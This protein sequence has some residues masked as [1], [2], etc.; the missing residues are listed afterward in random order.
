MSGSGLFEREPLNPHLRPA[1]VLAKLTLPFFFWDRCDGCRRV[2]EKCEGGQPCRRCAH[3]RRRC[4]FSELP[5]REPAPGL[6]H[7]R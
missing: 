2:K 7:K 6:Q 4:E 1:G 5:P 3:L